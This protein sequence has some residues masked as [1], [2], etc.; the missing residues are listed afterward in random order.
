MGSHC[1]FVVVFCSVNSPP[2]ARRGAVHVSRS[3]SISFTGPGV[4]MRLPS[5]SSGEFWL[6]YLWLRIWDDICR[7]MV[8][9]CVILWNGICSCL[10]IGLSCL[11]LL[12]QTFDRLIDWVL[13]WSID[14][15]VWLIDWLIDWLILF[16]T[17]VFFRL[18]ARPNRD[19][20]E[21]S[22]PDRFSSMGRGG[23]GA[24]G[25]RPRHHHSHRVSGG[26][27]WFKVRVR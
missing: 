20:G 23:R 1:Y 19:G 12:L 4:G 8:F 3:R 9:L 13:D 2:N 18:G 5:G 10:L 26:V 7:S 21:P 24:V 14:F 6:F 17:D 27:Q 11:H 25:D 15:F 16:I 22:G